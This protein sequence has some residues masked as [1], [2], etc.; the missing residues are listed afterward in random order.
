[1][2]T[3]ENARL[4][5][6]NAMLPGRHSVTIDGSAIIA[7]DAPA[8]A[9]SPRIDIGGMTL[10]PGLITSHFHPDFFRFTLAD[11]MAGHQF[12]KELPPGVCM[13]MGVRNA[14]KLIESGFTGYLGGSCTNDVDA[15]LK[16]AIAQGIIEGP[17]IR[18]ASRHINTTGDANDLRQW[19]RRPQ[20]PGIDLFGDGPEELR[21]LV[22]EEIRRGAEIIKVF[23]S[24][25][26]LIVGPGI[27]RQ[28]QRDELAAVVAAAHDR[29]ALV[30][31]HVCERD[32]ILEAIEFG[33]DIIDHGDEVDE[34]C[35]EAMVK[36]GTHWVPSLMLSKVAM[37]AGL[38]GP[39][40]EFR[41]GYEDV[42]RVLPLA[43]KAGVNLLIGD[44]YSG[45]LRDLVE[46]DPL[47]H[48]VGNYGREFAFY[49]EIDGI[50]P[51]D[52]LQWGTRN[53][54]R[55]LVDAPEKAGVIEAG[56]KADLIVIDGDPLADLGLL[57]RPQQALRLLIADGKTL[58]DRLPPEPKRMAA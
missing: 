54:G 11:A 9:G 3:L 12:G 50:E 33:V 20:T 14:G 35:I 31:S 32:M 43:Q 58:I 1:M 51:I 4:F 10:M 37:D 56:A 26:H 13:A 28:M 46:N 36:A 7:V 29:G 53:P 22:R 17:R 34:A 18:A 38:E 24:P 45:F 39:D 16:L 25:G 49:A 44:D 55:L 40:C 15:C 21:K 48:E 30:R 27:K 2:L 23:G 5:N 19:W 8:P 6:G 52:V 42:R 57:A 41:R 47:D